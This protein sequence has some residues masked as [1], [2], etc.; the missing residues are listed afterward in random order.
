MKAMAWTFLLSTM[1]WAATA[2]AVEPPA[3]PHPSYDL[4]GCIRAALEKSPDVQAIAADLAGARARLA[5]ARA[6]RFG[7]SE[8]NQIFG[9][10]NAAHGNPTFSPNNKNDFFNSLGPFTRLELDVHVPLYTFGKIDSALQAA[11]N[12]LESE[13][14]H[15]AVTRAE[16]VENV[17]QLYYGLLLTEQLSGI[18]HDML[19]RMDEAISKTKK[20]L[21][22]GS[23]TVTELDLLKL[24]IGRAKFAKGVADVDASSEITRSALARA[25]GVETA[26]GFAIAE[27]RLRPVNVELGSLDDYLAAGPERRPEWQ[28][29]SKG[30]DA[31]SAKLALEEAGYYP[32]FFVAT[33]IHFARAPNRDEQDNPF[34]SDDFNYVEPI[35]VLGLHWDLNFFT[36]RAKVEQARADLER[37]Q[38]EQQ[39]AQSGLRLEIRKAYTEVVQAQQNMRAAEQGRKAGRGLLILSVSNFDL[40]IG[41]AKDLFEGL[42]AYTESSTDYFRAVHDFNVGVGAL[43]RA[44]GR[45]LTDLQY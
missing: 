14:A 24:E 4:G 25:V 1:T 22:E 43:S 34:A 31:Q 7:E 27:Q 44:V 38:L 32:S 23:K 18:L 19:D 11:Q 30:I 13:R 39:E 6:A 33:G 41:E 37:L 20:R 17:K 12:A 8:Y 29:L 3:T 40:G 10:V 28:Q 45:E 42:G 36:T 5:E 16:V 35:G 26:T 9:L 21:D 2:T 15:G